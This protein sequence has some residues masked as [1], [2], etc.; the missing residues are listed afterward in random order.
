[1]NIE[2]T[3]AAIEKEAQTYEY[4]EHPISLY[5]PIRYL[6]SLGGKRIR[7][8]LVLMA[9]RIFKDDY[10]SVVKPALAVEVFHNFTLM[11]DDIMDKAPLRRGKATVHE[12]WNANIAILSGDV[13]LVKAYDLL[14]ESKSPVLATIIESFNE[15]A[16]FVC[17]GQ[18]LDMD[19]ETRDNV[20]VDEYVEMIKLKTSVLLGY[21]LKYG[22]L[23]AHTT[24]DNLYNLYNFGCY[25]G[26]GF[27]LKDDLLDVFGEQEKV[28]KQMGGDI[29][30]NKKTYLLIKALEKADGAVKEE[31][32]A[33]LIKKD[34][35]KEEK[36]N[37]VTSI[38]E[39][40]NLR[41]ET[42]ELMNHY[43]SLGFNYLKK[44]KGSEEAKTQL[45]EFSHYLIHR[46]K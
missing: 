42:E 19:F 6:M 32:S 38:Y 14:L 28:G 39:T 27:Q 3:I 25:I 20:T 2:E 41:A 13:M 21:S 30:A 23:L 43:F 4:G 31:L 44:V 8:L 12:K 29:I 11:H 15:T 34:F 37:A 24:P 9:Y 17:E 7:P 22:G 10:E 1:M 35:N 16:R 46:D 5:E 18:Q 40:L 33:W 36:V 26:I 45:E